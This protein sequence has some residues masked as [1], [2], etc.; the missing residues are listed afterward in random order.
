MVAWIIYV[1]RKGNTTPDD[2]IFT[3]GFEL[4]VPEENV[5]AVGSGM[6]QTTLVLGHQVNYFRGTANSR[7]RLREGD[8]V[9]FG[10]KAESVFSPGLESAT[11]IGCINFYYIS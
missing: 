10:F 11:C 7:R 4:Y 2:L 8:R 9:L 6:L 5:L 3:D 1:K